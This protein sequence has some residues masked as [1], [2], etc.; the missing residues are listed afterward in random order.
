MQKGEWRPC[1]RG[2]RSRLDCSCWKT[3]AMTARLLD[4]TVGREELTGH[5][6][7]RQWRQRLSVREGDDDGE[8]R[9]G[10]MGLGFVQ[11]VREGVFNR[12]IHLPGTVDDRHD[13]NRRRAPSAM[14]TRREE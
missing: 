2:G 4:T 14:A 13:D 11:R 3:K 12:E 7:A 6:G 5:A 9:K 1:A 8:A 10:G